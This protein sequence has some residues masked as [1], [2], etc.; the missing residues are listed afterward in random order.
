MSTPTMTPE[1]RP[2]SVAGLARRFGKSNR[3]AAKLMRQMQHVPGREPFTTEQW[4]AEWMAEKSIPRQSWINKSTNLDPLDAFAMRKA[5][6]LLGTMA[7]KGQ[8]MI[9][10]VQKDY[11]V[12]P[13]D[14]RASAWARRWMTAGVESAGN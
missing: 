12:P 2:I 14:K 9:I 13:P 10:A 11:T 3:W 6:E 7:R 8:I 1:T 4:L 5:V